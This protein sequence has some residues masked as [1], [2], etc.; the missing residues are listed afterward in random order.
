MVVYFTV[1]PIVTLAEEIALPAVSLTV[2]FWL[3]LTGVKERE[4]VLVD[5]EKLLLRVVYLSLDIFTV[6]ESPELRVMLHLPVLEV[7]HHNPEVIWHRAPPSDLPEI[8]F[9]I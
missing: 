2:K 3:H 5:A 1:E 7:T 8:R 4:T 6:Y 9:L